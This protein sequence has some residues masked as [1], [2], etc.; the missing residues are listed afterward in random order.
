MA[1]ELKIGT[2]GT[3]EEFEKTY[4]SSFLEK[5]GVQILK[6]GKK[7]S[8]FKPWAVHT[9]FGWMCSFSFFDVLTYM[10]NGIWDLRVYKPKKGEGAE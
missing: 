6:E 8:L 3:R 10:G 1:I 7:F 9:K 2:R 5:N 4:T